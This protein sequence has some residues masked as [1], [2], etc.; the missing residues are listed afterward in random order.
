[1]SYVYKYVSKCDGLV[2]Y[3]GLVNG[4]S[5]SDLA[6]RIYQHTNIDKWDESLFD[7][8]YLTC[9][10]KTDAEFLESSFISHYKSDRFYNKAKK[11]WGESALI[12][13]KNFMWKRYENG[14]PVPFSIQMVISYFLLTK[15][16]NTIFS[17]NLES[18][19]DVCGEVS[20]VCQNGIIKRMVKFF[21]YEN[22]IIQEI[23][24]A[25]LDDFSLFKNIQYYPVDGSAF[26]E[27]K[28]KLEE[29]LLI[30]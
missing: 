21:D 11:G 4:N 25:Y 1:M 17:G 27:F 15:N 13:H 19:D 16:E 20:I 23:N 8:F 26:V 14:Q 29:L 28:N 10:N 2:K 24:T 30:K 18:G 6:R 5:I 12:N 22:E 9:E 3:V 7:I